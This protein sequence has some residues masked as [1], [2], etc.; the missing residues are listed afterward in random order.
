MR[1]NK[2]SVYIWI[3][4]EEYLCNIWKNALEFK[5]PLLSFGSPPTLSTPFFSRL[6][7]LVLF[8]LLLFRLPLPRPVFSLFKVSRL[9]R[10][11]RVNTPCSNVSGSGSPSRTLQ[12]GQIGPMWP[13][14]TTSH[15]PPFFLC[16][17]KLI[18]FHKSES[19]APGCGPPD[20]ARSVLGSTQTLVKKGKK[21]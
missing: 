5:G 18:K 1:G 9:C 21:Y 4:S 3:A 11:T 7:L 10:G 12:R 8:L 2:R 17:T 19:G 14:H 16:R 13:A 15:F 6:L 20:L